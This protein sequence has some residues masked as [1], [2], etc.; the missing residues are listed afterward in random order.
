MCQDLN[1]LNSY[2]LSVIKFNVSP[3]DKTT[4]VET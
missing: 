1:V 2:Y 4:G 3:E